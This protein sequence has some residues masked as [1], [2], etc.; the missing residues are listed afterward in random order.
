MNK[1]D[2]EVEFHRAIA[3]GDNLFPAAVVLKDDT[4]IFCDE[5][6][7]VKLPSCFFSGTDGALCYEIFLSRNGY[8]IALVPLLSVKGVSACLRKK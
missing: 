6:S 1:E 3:R 5:Y 4:S 8:T 7:M 2:F